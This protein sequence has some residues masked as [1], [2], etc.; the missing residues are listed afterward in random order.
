M[1]QIKGRCDSRSLSRATRCR[2]MYSQHSQ[3][4]TSPF[5]AE[6]YQFRPPR[7]YVRGNKLLNALHAQDAA[8][9]GTVSKAYLIKEKKTC[10][11][12]T[13]TDKRKPTLVGG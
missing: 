12:I 10:N 2:M 4:F 3:M 7:F 13:E 8:A 6:L 9:D 5:T 1:L 11:T